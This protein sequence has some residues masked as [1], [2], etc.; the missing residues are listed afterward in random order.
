MQTRVVC[1]LWALSLVCAREAATQAC[2]G[3]FPTMPPP[4]AE[5]ASEYCSFQDE[6]DDCTYHY[7][8]EGDP[9]VQPN[10]TVRV[11]KKK[12]EQGP[13]RRSASAVTCSAVPWSPLCPLI[14]PCGKVSC[15][16]Y[17]PAHLSV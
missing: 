14:L 15:G 5:E 9:S 8:L 17:L 11:Q 10:T 1:L 12:G 4:S 16:Q 3:D 2:P 7:T 6:D 13:V